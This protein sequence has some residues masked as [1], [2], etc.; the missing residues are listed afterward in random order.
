MNRQRFG[1]KSPGEFVRN[2]SGDWAFLPAPLPCKIQWTD[3]LVAALSQADQ[4]IGRLASL[5]PRVRHPNHLVHL[6]LRR[7][8]ELSSRIENMFAGVRTMLLYDDLPELEEKAPQVR[9]VDNNYKALDFAV[10]ALRHRP[11]S[12]GLIKEMHRL[13]MQGVRGGDKT[14]GEFRLVQA[15]IGRTHNT[16][17]AR[18]VP[19]PPHL[20][21][22]AMD[23]LAEYIAIPDGLPPLIRA[24]TAHYQ[25]EAI[26]PFA[27]GNGRI[28]R[29]LVL[30]MLF[31]ER[32]IPAPL[33]NPSAPLL[34]RRDEYYEHLLAVSEQGRWSQ[35]IEFFVRGVAEEAGDAL[36]RLE[37][38]EALRQTYEQRL[39]SGH[40]T[41]LLSQSLDH[42][43][44]EP[45]VTSSRLAEVLGVGY[46]TA[47]KL[48]AKLAAADVIREVTGRKRG[49]VYVAHEL[50]ELFSETG[51]QGTSTH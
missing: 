23:A 17:E 28:G 47:G 49:K 31:A 13:L 37:S 22:A 39:R 32:V 51:Y 4:V 34:R 7:E 5:G 11:I 36:R 27:D 19:A 35:W 50:L 40:W 21:P 41:K 2:F 33:L 1:A 38:V 15:H 26:H 12:L 44:V 14:P 29:A 20:V 8:A 30:V 43:F 25:F 9:E 24:A 48:V 18:F 46:T 6:F 10:S 16:A 45:R 3:S 42:L